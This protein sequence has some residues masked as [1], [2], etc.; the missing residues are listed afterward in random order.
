MFKILRYYAP[1]I[2]AIVLAVALL[3]LQVNMDL[4]LPD[5]MSKIVNVGLQQG[6]IE[7]PVP[8]RISPETTER[9]LFLLDK[10]EAE[11]FTGF[12]SM[13]GK[14]A[15]SVLPEGKEE[16]LISDNDFRSDLIISFILA[17]SDNP[18]DA[19]LSPQKLVSM[20]EEQRSAAIREIKE[21]LRRRFDPAMLEQMALRAVKKEN[22]SMGIDSAAVQ[23]RYILETGGFMLI[24]ALISAAATITVGFLAAR[25]SAGVGRTLR[26]DL[27]RKIEGFSNAEFDHFS[28]ASLI[29]RNTN[30]VVQIQRVTFMIMRMMLMAPIMATGAVIRAF[31][32]APSMGWIIALAVLVLLGIVSVVM[33]IALPKFKAI[34]GLVD[35]IN[36]VA[37]EQLTGL[38]VVRA[39]NRQSFEKDRFDKAN[40]ELTDVNLFVNRLMVT[41]M[42]FITLIMNVLSLTIIWVGAHKVAESSLQVGDMMAFLQYAM[43]IVMSFLMLSMAFIF[44]PRA[45]VSAGRIDEV[46]KTEGSI[47]NPSRPE[48]FADRVRGKISFKNVSFRYPGAE[49]YALKNISFTAE[50]GQ[51]TAIIGSTGSGKSSLINLI[52]RFYDVSEGEVLMDGKDVRKITLSAL[53]KQ[54]GYV[55]QKS[56][57][58]AGT[59]ESNL[60]YG[61]EGV[62]QEKLEK[63]A[64]ISQSSEFIGRKE[65]GFDSQVSQGGA[66]VSGGQKQRISIARALIKD[67]PVLIFDDSF[68]ALDFKTDA[69]LRGELEREYGDTTRIIVAQRVSTI[70]QAEQILVLDDGKLV[71]K[72]RHSELMDNCPVYREIVLSQL[73][74]KEV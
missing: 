49:D 54:I 44:I 50:P 58:F 21:Q 12:Y 26:S 7:S 30:D 45:S 20:P 35:K 11:K 59:I 71:G 10:P 1:Y 15:A 33:S 64:R 22:E 48:S 37:R 38:L 39:F 13:S 62:D 8:L 60:S 66:N 51:T 65:E 36:K 32:K 5:Y 57:L 16:E 14:E 31:T 74:I 24:L 70:M 34:Q 46:L 3:F 67:C 63:A 55:P 69:R 6:G 43:Q 56:V 73:S 19:S 23:S 41:L 53:R 2:P 17:T 72:G 4:A 29:T 27:F 42:P 47:K 68:S 18:Q 9:L 52:P 61:S 25:V 40:R 28:T